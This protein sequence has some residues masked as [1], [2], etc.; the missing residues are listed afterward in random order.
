MF[1]QRFVAQVACAPD[2]N[3]LEGLSDRRIIE[4]VDGQIGRFDDHRFVL[5]RGGVISVRRGRIHKS[6][7]CS[8]AMVAYH[9]LLEHAATC[10][11]LLRDKNSPPSTLTRLADGL[12]KKGFLY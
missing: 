7:L 3:R 12:E 10:A 6:F 5:A 1:E 4:R 11:A 8:R 2:E 9:Q